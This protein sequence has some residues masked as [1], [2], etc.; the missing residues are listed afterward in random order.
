MTTRGKEEKAPGFDERL[1]E[2]EAIVSQ[3]EEGG[4]GLEPAI[5]RYQRGIELLKECHHTLAGYRE[6]VEELTRDAELAL[7]PF[8]AD[9]D[10]A[11][12]ESGG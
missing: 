4:M 8:E 12:G 3:L 5:E 9:P 2:L 6:R 7:K 10:A 11:P 1:S